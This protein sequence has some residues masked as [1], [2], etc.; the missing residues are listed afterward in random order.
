MVKFRL[1]GIGRVSRLDRIVEGEYVKLPRVGEK[2]I[3]YFDKETYYFRVKN[4]EHSVFEYE[5]RE[6]D[7]TIPQVYARLKGRYRKR[8]I[9]SRWQRPLKWRGASPL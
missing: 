9:P 4:V 1:R 8:N 7:S 6:I 3:V 2:V 5:P